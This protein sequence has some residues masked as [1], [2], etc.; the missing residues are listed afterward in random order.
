[1]EQAQEVS[2]LSALL[3]A[4]MIVFIIA[5]GVVLLYQQFQKSL[6]R[7]L[8]E[9]EELKN[10]HHFEQLRSSL[11]S[12]ES[13]RKRIAHDLHD[14]IGALLST[15]RIYLNL[16]GESAQNEIQKEA[17]NKINLLYDE[18]TSNVRRISHD[19]RPVILE[20]LGLIAAL[21]SLHDKLLDK[22]IDFVFTHS[23][24]FELKNQAEMAIYRILQELITNSLK[25]AG[26]SRIEIDLRQMDSV[27]ILNYKD[28][29]IGF[30]EKIPKN[31]LG[32]KSIESRL[33]LLFGS[34]Q[35]LESSKGVS[36]EIKFE[37]KNLV[38]DE[39]D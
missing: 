33:S 28:D 11:E 1:M 21:E 12:Q 31:G 39:P 13:E 18:I 16:L 8:L 7:Q 14:E 19:L 17:K 35:F 5:I 3:P 23:Y 30:G 6:F 10:K 20:N 36:I 32:M 38:K 15:S 27:F 34:M 29:G 4:A 25:H 26:A 37:I 24:S 9:K 22:G 2:L